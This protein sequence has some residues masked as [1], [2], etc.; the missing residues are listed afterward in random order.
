MKKQYNKNTAKICLGFAWLFMMI[1]C[2]VRDDYPTFEPK[3]E[4]IIEDIIPADNDITP[5]TQKIIDGTSFFKTFLLDSTQS[6]HVGIEYTHIRFLD[7]FD[8]K[9][10][11]HV[12]E[13][14]RSKVNVTIQGLSP[15]GDYLY[16]VTQIL[17]EMMEMNEPKMNGTLIAAIPGGAITTGQPSSTHVQNGRVIVERPN[18]VL[19]MVGVRKDNGA[20][21]VLNSPSTTTYPVPVVNVEEYSQIIGGTN[22]MLYDGDDVTYTTT[23]TVA[24]TSI[25]FTPDMQKIYCIAVDGVNDFSAGIMLNSKRTIFKALGCDNAF[26]TN[27]SATNSLGVRVP[28]KSGRFGYEYVLKNFPQSGEPGGINYAIGFVVE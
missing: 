20:I 10:S 19:P 1:S 8:R 22:W 9:V 13:I 21:E 12:L 2:E 14:D 25:G 16:H 7:E 18:K 5:L 6:I 3:E 28:S 15:F 23:T 11:M 27:G 17:P 4:E 24:R 26:Y